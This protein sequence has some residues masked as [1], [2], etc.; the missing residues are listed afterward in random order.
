MFNSLLKRREIVLP[1]FLGHSNTMLKYFAPHN[2][3]SAVYICAVSLTFFLT[4]FLY[5]HQMDYEDEYSF[6]YFARYSEELSPDDFYKTLPNSLTEEQKRYEKWVFVRILGILELFDIVY[7]FWGF[8]EFF[9]YFFMRNNNIFK[10]YVFYFKNK[11]KTRMYLK[12]FR[13][14]FFCF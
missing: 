10:N 6:D 7:E 13:L 3:R 2:L 12:I 1:L 11:K 8:F 5:K 14:I 4:L 9:R